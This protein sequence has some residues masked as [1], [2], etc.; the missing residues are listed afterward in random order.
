MKFTFIIP[1][2]NEE[3]CIYG[4]AT[5]LASA[6]SAANLD[7]E[8]LIVDDGSTDRSWAELSRASEDF[9][10]PD[11]T[12]ACIRGTRNEGEHGFGMALRWGL[13]HARG[14]AMIFYMA[15]LSDSPADAITYARKLEEGYDCVFGSRFI[16]GG[17]L[18]DYPG[19][20][21]VINRLANWF[22]KILF[23]IRLDD[24]TNAF[25]G[26]TRQAIEGSMPLL[27]KHFNITVELPLKTIVRGF[28]Y[29]IIPISWTNRKAGSSKLV[30][31]E[32]GSRYLFIVLYVWLEKTLGRGDYH[33]KTKRREGG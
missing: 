6:L 26:Y 25:K 7:F 4:T 20:K 33:R 10:T 21:L 5:S 18:I 32:M 12:R 31:R 11:P 8:I 16:P 22:V 28:S 3:G 14:D 9:K 30:L 23:G 2:R 17:S 27:S 24:T 29:A 13:S 19:H 1:C 15:D